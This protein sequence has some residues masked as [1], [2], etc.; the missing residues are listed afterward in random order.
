MPLRLARGCYLTAVE[1]TLAEQCAALL[2]VNPPDTVAVGTTAAA[3]H[4][5]WLPEPPSAPEFATCSR[6]R[7]PAE[8]TRSRKPQFRS[9]R[10]LIGM[11]DRTFVAGI[12]VTTLARTWWDLAV[13]LVVPDLVAAGDRALQ[14]GCTPD[15]LQRVV[16]Q[17]AR[18]RGSRRARQAVELL[19]ARSRSRPESHL[20]VAVWQ[21]GLDCFEVN[22]PIVDEYGQWL[23]EPDL[24][25]VRARIALEY[26]GIDHADPQQMRRDITRMTDLRQRGWLMLLYGPAQ[27]F[28][29]P[30]QIGPELCQLVRE[31]AP[32]IRLRPARSFL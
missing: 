3:L 28:G 2:E 16:R 11:E 4:D 29:R 22:N 21:A 9:H 32:D 27:V 19:D 31:R 13:E 30:W 1:P 5:I 17:M 25:C 12:P 18:H 24:S 10:R 23:A 15:E 8:M 14:L 7:R 20:R 6:G 26:Q